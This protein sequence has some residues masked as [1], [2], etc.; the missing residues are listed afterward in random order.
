MS[1]EMMYEGNKAAMEASTRQPDP[2]ERITP[3]QRKKDLLIS[4]AI[5]AVVI[6][7]AGMWASGFFLP[8]YDL[9]E[10]R[11]TRIATVHDGSGTH[12]ET[13]VI[14]MPSLAGRYHTGRD[15]E[16]MVGFTAVNGTMVINSLDSLTPEFLFYMTPETIPCTIHNGGSKTLPLEFIAP[17]GSW[18]GILELEVRMDL[19]RN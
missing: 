1:M 19:Y 16:L 5:L 13:T 8:T 10:V 4:V 3:K 9:T 17:A 18:T 6:I 7:L 15:M 11:Q 2:R 12:V 14:S